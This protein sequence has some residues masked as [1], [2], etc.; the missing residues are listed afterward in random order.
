MLFP[1]LIRFVDVDFN[2][3]DINF[4]LE[5]WV[6]VLDLLGI[7]AA[8]V[9]EAT[10]PVSQVNNKQSSRQEDDAEQVRMFVLYAHRSHIHARV[11]ESGQGQRW[12]PDGDSFQSALSQL[13]AEQVVVLGRC[14]HG[15]PL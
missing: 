2:T 8:P 3:L 11:I 13:S 10:L 15:R 4:N 9:E 14:G 7:G 1:S 12:L 5:T 6:I